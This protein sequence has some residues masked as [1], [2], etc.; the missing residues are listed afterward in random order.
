MPRFTHRTLLQFTSTV[1]V[2]DWF[3]SPRYGSLGGLP[4]ALGAVKANVTVTSASWRF[5]SPAATRYWYTAARTLG[6]PAF[7]VIGVGLPDPLTVYP[8]PA[9]R[10]PS[11]A[12]LLTICCA[13]II[14][15]SSRTP[16]IIGATN[17]M[18]TRPISTAATP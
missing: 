18:V 2:N 13:W 15:P 16:T 9:R 11:R 5:D 8:W 1:T 7:T 6:E 12:E 3:F 10:A 17:S 4:E 14:R